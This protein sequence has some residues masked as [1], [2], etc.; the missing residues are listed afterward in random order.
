VQGDFAGQPSTVEGVLKAVSTTSDG[1][2]APAGFVLRLAHPRCVVG[3]AHASFLVEVYIA[4][5]GTDL[6]PF[7]DAR[8]RITGDVIGGTTDVGGAAVVI[9]AKDVERVAAAAD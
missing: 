4:T 6:R 7:L 8:V 1:K 3:V 5:T 2:R 9:L